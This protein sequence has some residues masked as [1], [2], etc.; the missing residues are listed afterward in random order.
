MKYW[1][2][3]LVA[4]IFAAITWAL[5]EF[6]KAHC[7]LVDM[8]YPY[9]TRLVVTSMADWT[10]SMNFCLWQVL[11]VAMVVIV[12]V[13]VA[14]MVVLKWNIVQ[15]LG[16]VVAAVSFVAMLNTGMFGLNRYASPLADDMR[17]KI[18]EF[19]VSELN[20]ATQYFR[21]QAGILAAEVKRNSKGDVETPDFET[22]AKQAGEGFEVL[23]YEDAISVFAGSTV[24][25]KK[26]DWASFFDGKFGYTVAMTGEA[27]V[28]PSVPGVA[29]PFAMCNEMAHRM[30][31][32]SDADAAF[33]AYLA[34]ISNSDV[35]FQYAGYLMA[36]LYCYNAL[37]NIPTSTAQSCA[38]STDK[39]VTQMMR[40]DM[41]VVENFLGE[42]LV[43]LND[44]AE[45]PKEAA[46]ENAPI[47]F[48][49][50]DDVSDL[51][52]NWYIAKFVTPLHQEEEITFNPLDPNQV[53][54]TTTNPTEATGG[55]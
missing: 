21:D 39:G 50:Y 17:L 44:R 18:N 25:V 54:L 9:M 3:Y 55:A 34:C 5:V 19:T 45:I 16:W 29:L 52:A 49:A 24:P 20:E 36:Y 43:A 6:A 41:Q 35:N 28:N 2:G 33:S 47:H 27:A 53:D 48:S 15:W 12:I 7:M 37:K 38:A 32:Y 40:K 1:R 13:S 14:L 22:L 31:I 11:L 10:S 23:C 26:L 30:S 4:A 42:N 51:L 8:V 46:A